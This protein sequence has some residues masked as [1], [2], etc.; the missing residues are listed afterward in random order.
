MSIRPFSTNEINNL[1]EIIEKNGF[2]VDSFIENYFRCGISKN[3]V[4]VFTLKF[5]VKLP[6]RLNIPFEVVS[7]H[8]SL[9]FRFFDLNQN[10]NKIITKD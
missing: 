2:R 4:L 8:I 5:P 3:K 7:F 9:A 1:K 10:V 6:V